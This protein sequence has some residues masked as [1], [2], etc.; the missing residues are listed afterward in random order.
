MINISFFSYKGGAGRTSLLYNTLPFL[1]DELQ[2]TAREPIVVIDLDLDSKGLSLLNDASGIN[3]IQVLRNDAAIGFGQ[4]RA[5]ED[6]PFFQQLAPIGKKVGL[7]EERDRSILFI[8]AHPK[9]GAESLSEYGNNYDNGR[10][11]LNGLSKLCN[12]FHCKAIVMDCPAGDQL[13]A[14]KSLSIANKIVLTMRITTQ[15]RLGSKEF[16]EKKSSYY[17]GKEYIIVPN[18]VPSAEGTNFDMSDYMKSIAGIATNA[19]K[20]N[21]KVN[22]TFLQDGRTGIGE[23]NLF[24]FREVNLREEALWRKLSEDEER[25]MEMYKLLAEELSK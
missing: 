3:A 11:N 18:A 17:S 5:I 1:A 10:V 9:E 8:T 15:F 20:E 7:S 4:M 23:V 16:L 19:V 22:L 13:T 14:K 25:A 24:K 12:S 2:A 6:H 21:G